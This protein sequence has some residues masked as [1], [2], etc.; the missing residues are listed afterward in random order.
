MC[1]MSI[2][3][4][5]ALMLTQAPLALAKERVQPLPATTET[6]APARQKATA[7]ERAMAQ[8][9]D[10]LARAT[11]WTREVERDGR[12]AGAGV[13]LARAMRS[14][15]KYDEAVEAAQR[16]LLIEPDNRDA[17]LEVA[18]AHISRGQGF[19]AVA[20]AQKAAALAPRDWRPV[21]LLAVALEQASRDDEALAA[22]QKAMTLAPEEPSVLANYA[23]YQAG[24]GQM[25]D[26]ERMLRLAASKPTANAYIRQNLALVLGMQGRLAEAEKLARQDLPPEMVA[27]NLAYLRAVSGAGGVPT[28][29]SWDALRAQP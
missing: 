24:H 12:D 6:A 23:M 14:L 4:A 7:E 27:N 2:L 5:T 21:S 13:N 19:Y 16:V 1:R 28:Q 11:F 3:A 10:P 8:R 9:G 25:A 22:H 26:A 15:G 20:P 29:R 18:R 17:L